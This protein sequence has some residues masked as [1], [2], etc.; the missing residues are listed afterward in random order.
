ML[1]G[2]IDEE[3]NISSTIPLADFEYCKIS[4][5]YLWQPWRNIGIFNKKLKWIVITN[6]A[7]RSL[8]SGIAIRE[9]EL[10]NSGNY[11]RIFLFN[12]YSTATKLFLKNITVPWDCSAE[13]T[14]WLMIPQTHNMTTFFSQQSIVY[15]RIN[16]K[17]QANCVLRGHMLV[18]LTLS[19]HWG[20]LLR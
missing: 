19:W 1:T 13:T 6:C 11:F 12:N 3:F 20:C 7:V 4:Y 2:V 14:V 15:L 17:N 16:K 9:K 8:G 5:I 10:C 18:F